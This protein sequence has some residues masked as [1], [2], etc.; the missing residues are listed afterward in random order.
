MYYDLYKSK[1]FNQ[2]YMYTKYFSQ[3]YEL[4]DYENITQEQQNLSRFPMV[5]L[6]KNVVS[7][8]L[9]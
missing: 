5:N 3:N 1:R 9:E 7:Y 4:S 6:D 2:E 8:K